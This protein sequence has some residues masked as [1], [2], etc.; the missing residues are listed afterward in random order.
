VAYKAKTNKD[1]V[2]GIDEYAEDLTV[3]PPSVWDPALRIE[4]PQHPIK[5]VSI[6]SSLHSSCTIV[7]IR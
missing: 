7:R 4:P 1:L 3:L 5:L 6:T 2:A